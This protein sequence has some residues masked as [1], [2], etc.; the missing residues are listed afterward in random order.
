MTELSV[1]IPTYNRVE[2]LRACLESLAEQTHPA[3]EFEVIV[4]VDGSTDGT[5]AMLA[6]L[7]VPFALR[8][9]EQTNQ[10]QNRA[11]NRGASE[12]KGPYLLF[13]DDDIRA[14]PALVAEHLSAQRGKHGVVGVGKIA[15]ELPARPDWFLR[16]FAEGWR[17]HYEEL[18]GGEKQPTWIDCYTGNV[19]LKRRAFFGAGGFSDDV[20]RGD[21]IELG[22]RLE[23][24]GAAFTYLPEALGTQN[25]DK[26]IQQLASDFRASGRAYVQ[27]ARRYPPITPML[28]GELAEGN[29]RWTLLRHALH[30]TRCPPRVLGWWGSRLRDRER[31]RRWFYFLQTFFYWS[32]VRQAVRDRTEW[33]RLMSGTPILMYHAFT[34]DD[35]GSRFVIP[36]RRFACQLKW[37]R[38]L[39]YRVIGLEEFLRE[40]RRHRMPAE[41]SVVVTID[42]AY[43]ETLS[44]AYPLLRR[45]DGRATVFAVTDCIGAANAWDDDGLRGR[46]V[47]AWSDLDRLAS[48]GIEIGAH[49]ATHPSLLGLPEDRVRAEI[50]GS[51]RR[52]EARLERPVRTFAYPYGEHDGR[53]E[54]VAEEAGFWGACGVDSGLNTL[55]TP[56]YA[57]RR[58]EVDGRLPLFRFLLALWV[59]DTHV[60]AG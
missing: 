5:R 47:L 40:R 34:D 25:E 49:T 35:R 4:V 39:G 6:S 42:D 48:D 27:L 37:M 30:L 13:L 18:D 51:K 38:R 7:E 17:R 36:T 9:L 57:L 45:H 50:I 20:R 1:I 15:L 58:V 11:R 53:C 16:H 60:R 28:L 44:H 41:R 22:Y 12:A 29:L 52:L 19:S 56:S 55:G 23:T 3:E 59:G 2:R 21:D 31:A 24:F 8:V 43:V 46:R 10:G 32:G 14:A 33:R 54:A 26:D